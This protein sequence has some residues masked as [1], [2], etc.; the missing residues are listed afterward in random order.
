M[1]YAGSKE[2][3]GRLAGPERRVVAVY[4]TEYNSPLG[5]LTLAG[6][7]AGLTGLWLEGQTYFG[8]GLE[9]G[10]ERREDLAVFGAA[11]CWLDRYFAGERP[12][13]RELPLSPGGTPFQRLIWSLLLDIPWGETVTYGALARR[14]ARRLGR[15]SMSA[16]AVGGAVSRNPIAIVIPCHRVVGT[17]GSLT[18]YAGGLERKGWL[19]RWEGA[20]LSHCRICAKK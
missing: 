18:G 14:A 2:G 4:V 19:L 6:G 10:A 13:G 8:R 9:P 1:C 5:K 11:R 15:E 16:Q 17:D 20:D 3:P 12:R 7:Q